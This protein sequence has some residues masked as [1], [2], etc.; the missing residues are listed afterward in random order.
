MSLRLFDRVVH[1]TTYLVPP[2]SNTERKDTQNLC[3]PIR[4]TAKSHL[5][6]ELTEIIMLRKLCVPFNNSSDAKPE[7][8][9]CPV[10]EYFKGKTVTSGRKD[11]RSKQR[12]CFCSSS[13]IQ[14]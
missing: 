1:E 5:L 6:Q 2:F 4:T 12:G 3:S 8:Y 14:L 7:N 13:W 11:M 10:R 9:S